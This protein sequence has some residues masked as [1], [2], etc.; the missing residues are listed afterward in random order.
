MLDRLS[1]FKKYS[2]EGNKLQTQI[3]LN[4]DFLALFL[5]LRKYA[6]IGTNLL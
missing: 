4:D 2:V 1:I 3:L 5:Y 6:Y